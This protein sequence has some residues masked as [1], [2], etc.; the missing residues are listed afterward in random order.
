LQVTVTRLPHCL[1]LSHTLGGYNLE[2]SNPEE[3]VWVMMR[4]AHSNS[5]FSWLI[6][7]RGKPPKK[8]TIIGIHERIAAY[9]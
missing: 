4:L 1:T 9:V 3:L 8:S 5:N 2:V 6:L 7:I